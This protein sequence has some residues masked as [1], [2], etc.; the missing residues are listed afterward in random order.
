MSSNDSKAVDSL[1]SRVDHLV[2]GTPELNR[3]IDEIARLTGVRASPGGQHPG[4]GTHNALLRLGPTA[5]LEIIAPDP[6]Q[7]APRQPR[8]FGIDGL[9]ESKLVTWAANGTDLEQFR[10]AALRHGVQ[11]GEVHA[12]SRKTPDGAMLSWRS[13]SLSAMIAN[14]VVPFFIDWGNSSHPSQ[15]AATGLTLLGLRG[16]HPEPAKVRDILRKLGISLPVSEGPTAALVAV[17]QGPLG[18]VE[19]C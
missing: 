17:I 11:L 19:L 12:G 4:G 6:E 3:G 14:G 2:Y 10:Q 15:A 7:P 9:T 18:R 13:T 16:E 8:A 5:Y 1:L